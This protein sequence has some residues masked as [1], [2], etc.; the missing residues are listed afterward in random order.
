[1]SDTVADAAADTCQSVNK[2]SENPG[3]I[4][5]QSHLDNHVIHQQLLKS[6]NK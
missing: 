1:M 6:T 4:I 5:K 2:K 3:P